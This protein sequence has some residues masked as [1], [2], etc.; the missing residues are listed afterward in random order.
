MIRKTVLTA[1]VM[2]AVAATASAQ[3][4]RVELSGTAGWTF[5]DGV[6]N[7]SEN[8]GNDFARIDPDDAFSWGARLGF[9][10]TDNV[11]VGFLFG[12][13]STKLSVSAVGQSLALGD[14]SIYNYHGYVAYN[15][16]DADSQVRPYVLGGLGA[17]QYGTVNASL[18]G[19][20]RDIPGNTK[21]S[22]TWA[23]GLKL[24][25]SERFG[26]RLEGRWTPTYIK[27]DAAGWWCDPYWGCY[28]VGEAQYSNQFELSGGINLRF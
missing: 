1:L 12:M 13:Q 14:E 19:E 15:F 6:S 16:L 5:S 23:A 9:M 10:A 4:P 27:S 22:S 18:F 3:N 25:P 20:Q 17:T 21:F 2:V 8:L 7:G 28:T 24:Y 26:I 11:E